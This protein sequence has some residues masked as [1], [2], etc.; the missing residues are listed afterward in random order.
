MHP[1]FVLPCYFTRWLPCMLDWLYDSATTCSATVRIVSSFVKA[2]SQAQ[3]PIVLK[4]NEAPYN[5]N[6]PIT[7][8]LEY[9]AQDHGIK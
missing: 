3:I 4:I 6:C 8:I 1:W 9:Q 7:L 5:A 2:L